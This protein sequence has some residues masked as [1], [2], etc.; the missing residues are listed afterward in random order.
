[1]ALGQG[2]PGTPTTQ[3]PDARSLFASPKVI[4]NQDE[5]ETKRRIR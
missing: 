3:R 5:D 1:M 2:D 4:V